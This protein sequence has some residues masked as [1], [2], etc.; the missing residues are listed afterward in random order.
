MRLGK[1]PSTGR[2]PDH[3]PAPEAIRYIARFRDIDAARMHFHNALS[4]TLVDIDSGL[5]RVPLA[6]AI[7]TIEA[8]DLRHERI[9]LDPDLP[10]STLQQVQ[11]LITVA[12]A[13]RIA[14]DES[15]TASA[16]WHCCGCFSTH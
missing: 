4:R 9:W 2:W 8:S 15:G 16:C 1:P 10:A 14:A 7:A 3:A 12:A 6:D 11:A 5:Y 13:A